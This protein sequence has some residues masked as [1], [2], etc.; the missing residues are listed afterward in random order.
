METD[1]RFVGLYMG[2]REQVAL[3]Y[4]QSR[5]LGPLQEISLNANVSTCR[6]S[7]I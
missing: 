1:F 3:P 7:N 5:N 4:L 6:V 2:F